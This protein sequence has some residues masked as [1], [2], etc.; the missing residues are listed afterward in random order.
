MNKLKGRLKVVGS[1]ERKS[2]LFG[3][4]DLSFASS[5]TIWFE[6]VN[7]VPLYKYYHFFC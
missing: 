6:I 2:H 3:N 7:G 5:Y 4:W 1:N